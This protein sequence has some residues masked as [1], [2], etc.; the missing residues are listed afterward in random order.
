MKSR[1]LFCA[2]LLSLSGFAQED[3]ATALP[4]NELKANLL[5]TILELP[6]ITYKRVLNEA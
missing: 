2:L 5:F 1:L 4:R 6:E 3:A